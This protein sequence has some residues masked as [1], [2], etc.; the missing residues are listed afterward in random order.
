MSKKNRHQRRRRCPNRGWLWKLVVGG[1]QAA[2]Y[3]ARFWVWLSD[4]E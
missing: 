2:Y 3:V 4:R 1:G